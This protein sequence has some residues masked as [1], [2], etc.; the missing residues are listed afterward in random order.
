MEWIYVDGLRL[1]A[2]LSGE[3]FTYGPLAGIDKVIRYFLRGVLRQTRTQGLL[4][5]I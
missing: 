3:T 1:N 4:K 5:N 2:S